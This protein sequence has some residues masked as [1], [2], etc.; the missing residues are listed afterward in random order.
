MIFECISFLREIFVNRNKPNQTK[1]KKDVTQKMG[2]NRFQT[3]WKNRRKHKTI[4]EK[5]R[6]KKR[7]RKLRKLIR[8][9]F[10]VFCVV[11]VCL[12]VNR[13]WQLKRVFQEN[14]FFLSVCLCV[15]EWVSY[16]L[17]WMFA[18]GRI[19]FSVE[20]FFLICCWNE[21]SRAQL[22]VCV[23]VFFVG[24]VILLF[25]LFLFLRNMQTYIK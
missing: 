17:W 18:F 1:K 19:E 9:F 16:Y 3:N 8:F 25:I 23:C 22:M 10:F 11:A 15:S 12:S 14:F 7:K 13:K 2:A 21:L 20:L 6:Y 4:I 5:L 24:M